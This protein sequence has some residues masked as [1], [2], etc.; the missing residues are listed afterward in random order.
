[1]Y[2][3]YFPVNPSNIGVLL[4]QD[5]GLGGKYAEIKESCRPRRSHEIFDQPLWCQREL[6][7]GV[8]RVA[9][10]IDREICRI[11]VKL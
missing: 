8:R 1:M 4:G 11:L 2:S 6:N 5:L 9:S 10:W 3:A 7:E